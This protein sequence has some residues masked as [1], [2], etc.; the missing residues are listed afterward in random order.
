M[1]ILKNPK[2]ELF[3]Q[4]LAKGSTADKAYTAAGYT[5]NP[6]N[7][8]RMKLNEAIKGR[9]AEILDKGLGKTVATIERIAEEMQ[10]IALCDVTEGIEVKKGKVYITDSASLSKDFTAAISGIRSTKEG[11]EVR[12]HDKIAAIS[13][14]G[15]HRGMFKETMNLTVQLSLAELVNAS[16]D[17]DKPKE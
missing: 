16:Y 6:G 1:P 12:F 2:H 13:L 7:A 14:L 11:V 9:I 17:G 10:R 3:A 4:E 5:P 15:K 8:T